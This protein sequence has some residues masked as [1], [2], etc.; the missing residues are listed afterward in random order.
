MKI[1]FE[2][3]GQTETLSIFDLTP[4]KV[5][6]NVSDEDSE[7]VY[8]AL[9]IDGVASLATGLLLDDNDLPTARFLEVDV[10]LVVKK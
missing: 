10:A 3:T 2:S 6:T 4:G 1:V 5:Y 7:D 9:D 8:L